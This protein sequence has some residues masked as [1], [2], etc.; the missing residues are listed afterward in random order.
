MFLVRSVIVSALLWEA[1]LSRSLPYSGM[2][3]VVVVGV[4]AVLEMEQ[5]MYSW[6]WDGEGP[7]FGT[8]KCGDRRG[9]EKSGRTLRGF[10]LLLSFLN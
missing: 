5:E 9:P 10:S 6:G 2:R 1:E 7:H 3:V 8:C 4:V